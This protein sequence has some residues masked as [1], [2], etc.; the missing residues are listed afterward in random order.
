MAMKRCPVC[1]E[2]YSDTACECPFCKEEDVYWES[3]ELCRKTCG[4]KRRAKPSIQFRVLANTLVA[5]IVI[6]ASLLIYL[7]HDGVHRVDYP[8]KETSPQILIHEVESQ[9]PE[10]E[11]ETQASVVGT[12]T[13]EHA[14]ETN[15]QGP[16]DN[17]DLQLPEDSQGVS[18]S[19]KPVPEKSEKSDDSSL[20]YETAV[21]LPGGLSLSSTDFTLSKLGQTH[22]LRASGG[23]ANG[24]T[25]L[26][27]DETI[28]SVDQNGMVKAI[29]GGSTHVLVTDGSKKATC[30]VRIRASGSLLTIPAQEDTSDSDS[31]TT[32]GLKTGSAVVINA[33]NGVRVRSGPGT[34]Y[35]ALVSVYNGASIQVLKSAGN[36]WYE[37]TFY[38]ARG[39][40]TIGYM[41]S[42]FLK[43]T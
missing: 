22:T 18:E 14:E 39:A 42:E 23:N 37:I 40:E 27:E 15:A 38:N 33:E 10:V 35:K 16:D 21:N 41:M 25:W 5:S 7:M 36:D 2:K 8:K 4:G 26:S 28:V 1:G 24:Y 17:A 30:I 32:P 29:S 12:D 3:E 11:T 19:E 43:N 31:S 13:Q 20:D 34:N 9:P 6:V